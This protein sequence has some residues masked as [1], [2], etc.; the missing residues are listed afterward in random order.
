MRV[1]R[2]LSE[3]RKAR[4]GRKVVQVTREVCEVELERGKDLRQV[5]L[6]LKG[7]TAWIRVDGVVDEVVDWGCWWK[8]STGV[9]HDGDERRRKEDVQWWWC[10]WWLKNMMSKCQEVVIEGGRGRRMVVK[11]AAL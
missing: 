2:G 1:W 7:D 3:G 10:W 9:A 6:V 5:L 4:R 8:W 11:K